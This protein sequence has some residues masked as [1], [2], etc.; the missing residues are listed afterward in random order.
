MKKGDKVTTTRA[1]GV[2]VFRGQDK[3]GM[4]L[5][6][7]PKGLMLKVPMESLSKI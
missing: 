5:I 3:D 6:K 2:F 7:K 4:A 1:E